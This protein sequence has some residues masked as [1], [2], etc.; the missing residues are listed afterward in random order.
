MDAA[1]QEWWNSLEEWN[2][3]KDSIAHLTAREKAL[4]E[5]LFAGSFPN[6]EEGVNTV[7]LPDGRKLKGTHK[8]NRK[9][10]EDKLQ[11]VH[12]ELGADTFQDVFKVKYDLVLAAYRKLEPKMQKVVDKALEVKPG[13]PSLE[14]VEA[15][16]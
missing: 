1:E 5:M 8:L 15:K 4:R 3:L 9:V 11:K 16:G 10:L 6:P 13:L 14:L 12:D 7:V 2:Q